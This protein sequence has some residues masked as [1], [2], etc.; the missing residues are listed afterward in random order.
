MWP[1]LRTAPPDLRRSPLPL[2]ACAF[3]L[4]LPTTAP[5]LPSPPSLLTLLSIQEWSFYS[6]HVF[7]YRAA[8]AG[9]AEFRTCDVNGDTT[10]FGH[11]LLLVD[12]PFE[13]RRRAVHAAALPAPSN[14]AAQSEHAPGASPPM[15]RSPLPTAR[16]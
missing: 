15:S 10:L 16:M 13:V 5:P 14:R 3:L 11:H 2:L 12:C 1:R 7:L 9:T 4:L 6:K 8:Q